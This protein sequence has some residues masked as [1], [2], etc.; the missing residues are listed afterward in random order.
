M[1]DINISCKFCQSDVTLPLA[2]A[3]ENEA[4][5]CPTCCKAFPISKLDLE[6]NEKMAKL[7]EYMR[8]SQEIS[9]ESDEETEEEQLELDTAP[10]E[11]KKEIPSGRQKI[12][13]IPGEELDYDQFYIKLTEL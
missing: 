8:L 12:E 13:K 9:D 2:W 3:K 6:K 5:F 4:G 10:K 1:S 7:A 11:E